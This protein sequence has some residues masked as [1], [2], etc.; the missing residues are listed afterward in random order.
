[1]RVFRYLVCAVV[2]AGF[3]ACGGKTTKPKPAEPA[4]KKVDRINPCDGD[5]INP[6][7]VDIR[8]PCDGP[9]INPCDGVSINP[10]AGDTDAIVNPGAGEGHPNPSGSKASAS[11]PKGN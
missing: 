9:P 3:A 4:A 10:C 5:P 8:N 6:C 11:S 7:G 1:M 2:L